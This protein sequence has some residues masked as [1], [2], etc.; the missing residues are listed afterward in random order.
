M[1]LICIF[2][3]AQPQLLQP[4]GAWRE[5]PTY[6]L[7]LSFFLPLSLPLLLV[8]PSLSLS[9][10]Y[11]KKKKSDCVTQN[12]SELSFLTCKIGSTT[13]Y[14]HQVIVRTTWN[15]DR[16]WYAK[17]LTTRETSH[18]YHYPVYHLTNS[19]ITLFCHISTWLPD[20]PFIRI[21]LTSIQLRYFKSLYS[22]G[23]PC[24]FSTALG[25]G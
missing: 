7:S 12:T 18:H 9:Q 19:S 3:L 5:A 23:S 11:T 14:T 8:P 25:S 4:F 13:V 20:I 16:A 2:G 24:K 15:N 21:C 10:K 17:H 1:F 6:F 22:N